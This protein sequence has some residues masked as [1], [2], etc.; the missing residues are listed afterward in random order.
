MEKKN[1]LTECAECLQN[2]SLTFTAHLRYNTRSMTQY[3]EAKS[4]TITSEMIAVER[5][6]KNYDVVFKKPG[7]GE[8]G[9]V[10]G[11]GRPPLPCPPQ[12]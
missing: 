12:Q 9:A 5:G 6:K 7:T 8:G 1:L 4:G 10:G 2:R 3:L 11:P